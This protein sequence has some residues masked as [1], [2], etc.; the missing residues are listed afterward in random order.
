M[1]AALAVVGGAAIASTALAEE[2]AADPDQDRAVEDG[3]GS[4]EAVEGMEQNCRMWLCPQPLYGVTPLDDWELREEGGDG[5]SDETT[6]GTR[7]RG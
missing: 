1:S 3:E 6:D 7:D 5:G 2:R 4:G